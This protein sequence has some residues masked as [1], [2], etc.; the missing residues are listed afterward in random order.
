M[1][2]LGLLILALCLGGPVLAQGGAKDILTIDV[3][4]DVA[5]MD[6]HLQ[7]DLDSAAVFRNIFDHLVTR[8]AS[9]K[10]ASQLAASWH[11]AG[12]TTLVFDLRTDIAFQDGSKV[13][14]ADVVFSI[15]RILNPALKSPQRGYYDLITSAEITGPA[16]VTV[17]TQVPYPTLMAQLTHLAIV[18]KA[19]VERVGDATF[20]AQPIGTG[21]YKLREWRRGVQAVLDASDGN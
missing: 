5:T 9:G 16:Q 18:P 4:N 19:Y 14:P 12:E 11:Y 3:P 17:H 1:R 20:N 15:Q 7:S 21:S 10:F 6:P 2:M 13:T 8:D